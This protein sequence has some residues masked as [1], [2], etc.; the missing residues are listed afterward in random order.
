MSCGVIFT[1]ANNH[2][3]VYVETKEIPYHGK[4]KFE[5]KYEMR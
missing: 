2:M 1:T 5:M 3:L 4:H